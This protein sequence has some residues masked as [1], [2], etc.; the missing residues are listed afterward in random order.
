M[1][2]RTSVNAGPEVL[3]RIDAESTVVTALRDVLKL[4]RQEQVSYPEAMAEGALI[5]SKELWRK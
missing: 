1:P 4:G 3:E 2:T 5:A